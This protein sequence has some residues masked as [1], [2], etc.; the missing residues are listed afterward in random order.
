MSPDSVKAP[1]KSQRWM[2]LP[3][4]GVLGVAL[5]PLYADVQSQKRV[6]QPHELDQVVETLKNQMVAGDRLRVEPEWWLEPYEGVRATIAEHEAWPFPSLLRSEGLD[7][8]E[9]S[10]AKR[11]YLVTGFGR[12]VKAPEGLTQTLKNPELLSKSERVSLTRWEVQGVQS[13]RRLSDELSHIQVKRGSMDGQLSVCPKLD[14][15][16][17]CPGEGFRHV[18]LEARVTGHQEV[19]WPFVH[20]ATQER[21]VLHW[22]L[23]TPRQAKENLAK[24]KW[25]YVRLG[26][27]FEAISH[28]EG[29]EVVLEVFTR[30]QSRGSFAI[31]P[32][33]FQLYRLAFSLDDEDLREQHG[34]Q[35]ELRAEDASWRETVIQADILDGLSS[36]LR[37]WTHIVVD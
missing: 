5:A 7:V 2:A 35:L 8:L 12:E 4:V 33:D 9:A 1:V 34:I 10:L 27:T 32:H 21:L 19:F 31:K 23:H 22:N 30:G 36:D 6:P 15:T 16:H 24:A 17:L 11:L 26:Q 25:L 14:Q 20:P 13:L 3:L 18:R 28:P 29:S 37:A